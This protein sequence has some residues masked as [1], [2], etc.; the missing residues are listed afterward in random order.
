[1]YIAAKVAEA[2]A[3]CVSGTLTHCCSPLLIDIGVWVYGLFSERFSLGFSL[4]Y[5]VV[6]ANRTK[7]LWDAHPLLFACVA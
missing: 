2:T 5:N 3:L 6:E 7:R 4:M 1:M